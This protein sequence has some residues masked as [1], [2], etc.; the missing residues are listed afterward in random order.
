MTIKKPQGNVNVEQWRLFGYAL[1]DI[2]KGQAVELDPA[3][4]KFRNG[5]TFTRALFWGL[6][7]EDITAGDALAFVGEG[8]LVGR[9]IDS[10]SKLS[11][12]R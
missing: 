1:T 3:T 10:G 6:A 7:V 2:A 12:S 5:L 8:G 11:P 9:A 4:G